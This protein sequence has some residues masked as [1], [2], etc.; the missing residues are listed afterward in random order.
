VSNL[1]QRTLRWAV[2][3]VAGIAAAS[4]LAA[5]STGT[6]SDSSSSG[7]SE[8]TKDTIVFA[9]KEDPT[10]ID[11][12]QTTLTTALNI[13]RQVVDS[14]V[15][16]DPESGEI[17]PWLA[18]SFESND[19]LTAYTFTLRDGVTFS[20]GS[21]LTADVVKDNFDSLVAMGKDGSTA[22]LATQYLAGYK[23]TDV[24]DDS[25]FTVNFSQPNAPFLQGAST[26]TLGIVSDD[27]TTQDAAA[28]CTDGVIGSG[29]FVYDSYTPND[30]VKITKRDGYDWASEEREHTGDAYV[31]TIEFP[32]ITEASVRTGGLESGEFDIIQ[33][34]PYADEAR[35]T[36]D[37]YN[38][39]AKANTGVPTSL[40]PNM[41][42]DILSDD[43]VLKAILLGTDR[44]EINSLAGA[45]SGKPASSA[46]T[47]STPGYTDESDAMAYDPD[48]AEKLLEDD[49]WVKGDDGIR[50][51]DGKK[52]SVGVTAFYAQD[53][54]EA[55]QIQL[56]KIGVD[57]TIN[58]TDAGGFFGAIASGDYDFIGGGLTRTDPD[59]LRVLM[60]TESTGKWAIIDDPDLESVLVKQSQTADAD[61]RQ[62]LVTEAQ[63]TIIDNAYLIPLLETTQ[64]HASTAAVQ[65]MTFDSASRVSL[66]DVR[67]AE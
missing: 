20:D 14:L 33:D 4:L 10:C 26:M 51:K 52:L 48:A 9:I 37:D 46:L 45:S 54:F 22:S 30:S 16:Q 32:I 66:Y 55:A 39:Y 27:T 23:G 34:L 17:V 3:P 41:K 24:T 38:L 60:S 65:G 11:P 59:A 40:I 29:P 53:V 5:C 49:G 35:F 21:A 1:K 47:S 13:G 31:S 42:S 15:D 8:S 25:T 50:E 64:L 44:D 43:T 6:G 7:A 57:L 18:S 28:R 61:A 36:T 56:K 63:K 19:D 12:Q 67:A 62:D 58:M 2:V